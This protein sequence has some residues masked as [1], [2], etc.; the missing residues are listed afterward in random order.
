MGMGFRGSSCLM[1]ANNMGDIVSGTLIK[2]PEDD[3]TYIVGDIF[4]NGLCKLYNANTNAFKGFY[5]LADIKMFV[6]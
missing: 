1:T 3:T 4:L 5:N 6:R 2:L